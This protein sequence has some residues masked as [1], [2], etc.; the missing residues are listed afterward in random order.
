MF[1]AIL[2][3][4]GALSGIGGSKQQSQSNSNSFSNSFGNSQSG[5]F[6]DPNQNPFLQQLYSGG[7]NTLGGLGD[8][9]AQAQGLIN[10]FDLSGGFGTLG[11]L[12]DPTAQIETQTAALQE[13]LGNLFSNEIMPSIQGNAIGAGGLGG[14]R[15]GVAEGTAAGEIASQFTQ[16]VADIT[17]RANQQALQAAGLM[18]SYAQDAFNFGMGNVGAAFAPLQQFA[19]LLGGPTVLQS[20]QSSSGSSSRSKS[21][22][23][24]SGSSFDMGFDFG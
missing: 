21:S 5:S 7:A 19:S 15:Q 1:G 8:T 23:S 4:L 22:S 24:G 17:G 14:G 2:S 3:G 11:Q 16:G 6:I 9:G 12:A 10:Q 13:G 20:A 18:P